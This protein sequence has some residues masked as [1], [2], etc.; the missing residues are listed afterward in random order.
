M[1]VQNNNEMDGN[2]LRSP[3]FQFIFFI[4]ILILK[5][6]LLFKYTY[7]SKNIYPFLITCIHLSRAQVN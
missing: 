1:N 6:F 3:N 2:V 4:V 5:Y 7:L